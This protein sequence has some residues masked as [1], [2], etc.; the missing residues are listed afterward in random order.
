MVFDRFNDKDHVEWAKNVKIKFNYICDVCG[1]YGVP[2]HSHHLNSYDTFI[3][4]RYDMNNGVCI[5][6]S[7]H[8]I[9]HQIYKKGKNTRFQYEEFKQSRC[10]ILGVLHKLTTEK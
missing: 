5:C 9:F 6:Q 7:C 10:L 1:K 2:L 3:N 8:Q 4:Q